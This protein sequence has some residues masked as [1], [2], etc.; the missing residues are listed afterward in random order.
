MI[1]AR[2]IPSSAAPCTWASLLSCGSSW[3]SPSHFAARQ[4]LPLLAGCERHASAATQLKCFQPIA[5]Q[6]SPVGGDPPPFR[7]PSQTFEFKRPPSTGH[8]TPKA[9]DSSSNLQLVMQPRPATRAAPAASAT[10]CSGSDCPDRP[11][12]LHATPTASGSICSGRLRARLILQPPSFIPRSPRR[13]LLQQPLSRLPH[14]YLTC[15]SNAKL[16]LSADS[17]VDDR[18]R[19]CKHILLKSPSHIFTVGLSARVRAEC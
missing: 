1:R 11:V 19:P 12:L 6:C 5:C 14:A 17:W 10:R 13:T 8:A 9:S 15:C 3:A 2:R 4:Q 16:W 18:L 7:L